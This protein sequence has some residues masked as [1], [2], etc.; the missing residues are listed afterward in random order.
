MYLLVHFL[1]VGWY[2]SSG[3]SI[4]QYLKIK[5]MVLKDGYQIILEQGQ[6][7]PIQFLCQQLDVSRSGYYKWIN[8]I[9]TLN[10]HKQNGNDLIELITSIHSEHPSFG[11]RYLAAIILTKTS[12]K[13]SALT[14]HKVCKGIGIKSKVSHYRRKKAGVEHLNHINMVQL[15]PRLYCRS[16][17]QCR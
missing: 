4:L 11:Y 13:L 17:R 15:N 3:F 8:R 14:V 2:N 9:G 5:H 7:Y 10:W 16:T 1:V 6:S 12:W